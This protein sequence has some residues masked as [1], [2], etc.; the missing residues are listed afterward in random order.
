MLHKRMER[1][2]QMKSAKSPICFMFNIELK[3]R[4]PGQEQHG[5]RY[6]FRFY[7]KRLYMEE[8]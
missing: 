7:S 2:M 6:I 1:I 3:Y 8:Y 4:K 5:S